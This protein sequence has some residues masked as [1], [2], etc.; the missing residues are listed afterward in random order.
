MFEFVLKHFWINTIHIMDN[1]GVFNQFNTDHMNCES[2]KS[3]SITTDNNI[4]TEQL[5][6]LIN[7]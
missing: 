7:I 1:R 3:F 6:N 4:A 5:K 2:I